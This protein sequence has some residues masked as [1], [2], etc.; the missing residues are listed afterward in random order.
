MVRIGHRSAQE[1]SLIP[2]EAAV[3]FSKFFTHLFLWLRKVNHQ[4]QTLSCAVLVVY[5]ALTASVIRIGNSWIDSFQ[6]QLPIIATHALVV[7]V[8]LY[9]L[10]PKMLLVRN[11]FTYILSVLLLIAG[12]TFPLAILSHRLVAQE[13]I[14]DEVWSSFFSS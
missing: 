8:N 7:Y 11:Y 1:K 3:G 14:Q 12:A 5:T 6:R 10:L 13:V 4:A 2:K 9:L